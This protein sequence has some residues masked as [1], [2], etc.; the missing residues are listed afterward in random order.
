MR[1][2]GVAVL[3]LF[4]GAFVGVALT[5]LATRVFV[6]GNGSSDSA[7]A[8]Y[9]IGVAPPVFALF[10]SVVAIAIDWHLRHKDNP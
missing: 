2:I 4:S 8:A 1:T 10:G 9:T 7:D 5:D 3:G 6:S